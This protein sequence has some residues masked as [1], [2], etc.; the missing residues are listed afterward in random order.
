MA[1]TPELKP[2][3]IT[4]SKWLRGG[5][6]RVYLLR[7]DGLMC[8]LGQFCSRIA[9]LPDG[10]LFRRTSPA[11]IW[12]NN[13]NGTARAAIKHVAPGLLHGEDNS[14][15]ASTLMCVND[16]PELTDAEREKAVAAHFAELGYAV[17]FED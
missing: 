13:D 7:D 1:N 16:D 11:T 9:R 14:E 6:G 3:V 5:Y 15:L 8:C 2:F 17:T 10:D 12:W 4:R